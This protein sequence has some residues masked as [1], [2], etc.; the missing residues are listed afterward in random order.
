ML[1]A[2]DI[3]NSSTHVGLFDG[4]KLQCDFRVPTHQCLDADKIR[5]ILT[6]EITESSSSIGSAVI[7]S[8]VPSKTPT[9]GEAVSRQYGCFPLV[10]TADINLPIKIDVDEPENLGSD[11]VADAVAGFSMF[12]GPVVVVDLGTAVTVEVVDSDG[13][14]RGGAIAPGPDAAIIGLAERTAQLFAVA[15]E[16]PDLAVGR[17]TDEALKAGLFYGTVGQV[18]RI[19]EETMRQIGITKCSVVATGGFSELIAPH[20]SVITQVEP[21][22][23]LIGLRL[24]AEF[25]C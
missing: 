5:E 17:T 20:S 24:I 14:Y 13:I 21:N 2:I 9:W 19:V 6:S 25:N 23:T 7:A 12:G 3:G 11:R 4:D 10:V 18:D 22:L 16:L 1:L 8:V 15:L